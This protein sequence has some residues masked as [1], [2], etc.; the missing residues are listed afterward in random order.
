LTLLTTAAAFTA[1]AVSQTTYTYTSIDYP[2][3][4]LLGT[5]VNGINSF[6]YIVGYYL[7]TE[8]TGRLVSRVFSR[9]PDGTFYSTYNPADPQS[10]VAAG[11]SDSL[12]IVGTRS[13]KSGVGGFI[14]SQ[15]NFQPYDLPSG[16]TYLSGISTNNLIVGHAAAFGFERSGPGELTILPDLN[17]SFVTPYGVNSLGVIVGTDNASVIPG[18][19]ADGFMRSAEGIYETVDYPGAV[20]TVLAGINN[21]GV[22]VG[23]AISSSGEYSSFVYSEGQFSPISYPGLVK[24]LA[25]GIN[26]DG[27]IS[28]TYYDASQLFHGFIATPVN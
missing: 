19:R 18:V 14:A 15:G 25:L 26:A 11:I 1:T 13:I 3:S 2:A 8:E 27:V 28:G 24:T 22:A 17:G 23:Y 12:V 6:G 10:F 5:Y 4:P 7:A 21:S 16:V 9:R 20:T